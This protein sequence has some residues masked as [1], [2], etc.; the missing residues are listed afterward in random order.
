M[1]ADFGK[2]EAG[3]GDVRVGEG[4]LG[5][6]VALRGADV[7]GGFVVGPGEFFG[8][9]HVGSAA[10]AGHGAEEAAKA[11]GV[12]VESYERIVAAVTGLVLRLAGAER[13]GEVAPMSVE[14]VVG[15]LEHAADVGG[16]ALVEEEIGG[17][18]VVVGAVAA[19]EE[20]EGDEGIEKVVCGAWMEAEAGAEVGEGFG[21]LG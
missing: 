11:I 5:D 7:D 6:E 13:G 17:G 2:V 15:H 14:A 4:D 19:L 10:D 21:V 16:L 12:G 1:G 8:D 9:G 3:A 18:G 20:V